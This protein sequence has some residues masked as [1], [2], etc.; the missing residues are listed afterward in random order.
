M[1]KLHGP[2]YQAGEGFSSLRSARQM[3][4][5]RLLSMLEMEG[6]NA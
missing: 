4:R 3:A 6:Y 5:P 1:K 2:F